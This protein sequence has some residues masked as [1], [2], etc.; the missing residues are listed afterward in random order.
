LTK[1][2]QTKDKKMTAFEYLNGIQSITPDVVGDIGVK[3]VQQ[4]SEQVIKDAIDANLQ[5]LTFAGNP[6]AEVKPFNDWFETGEFHNNLSFL[7]TNDIQ[8]TSK[9]DGFAAIE[10]AFDPEDTIAPSA[11]ILQEETMQSIQQSF[12]NLLN[13]KL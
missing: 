5:G 9:G 4:N 1:A 10:Q 13:E 3:A 6:I 7:N 8:F 11:V 2:R 12:M